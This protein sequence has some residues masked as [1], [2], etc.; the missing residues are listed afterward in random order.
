MVTRMVRSMT[1]DGMAA[2]LLVL[3]ASK[4]CFLLSG[5]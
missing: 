1:T 3:T 5:G 2:M 4:A